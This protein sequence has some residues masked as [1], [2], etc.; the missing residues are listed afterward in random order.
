MKTPHRRVSPSPSVR[1]RAFTLVELLSVIVIIAILAGLILPLLGRFR[2]QA[3]AGKCMSN[4]RQM[5]VAFRLYAADNRGFL[6][7]VSKHASADT[8][9][10][11]INTKGAWQVE[12]SPYFGREM[13]QN[14]QADS[15]DA[16]Y[17]AQ[18]PDFTITSANVVSRGY[19]MNDKLTSRGMVKALTDS[20]SQSTYSYNFRVRE[21]EIVAPAV[22]I[23][24]ADSDTLVCGFVARH[25]ERANCLF[26]DGHVAAHTPAEADDL[27]ASAAN[28]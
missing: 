3:N 23:L 25:G 7:A 27:K 5:G 20:A 17:Q 10:G 28:N 22:T 12:I 11:S 19:G 18:C 1:S 26:V 2:A 24:T 13:K 9:K 16:D 14:V 21:T 15:N 8:T 6:P 4:L